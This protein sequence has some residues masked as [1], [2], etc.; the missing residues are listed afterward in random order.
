MKVSAGEHFA[1]FGKDEWI[2]CSAAAFDL[3]YLSRVTQS[4][5]DGPVYLRHA[6]QTVSILHAR[7][8]Y[9]MRLT[10]VAVAK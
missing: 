3:N 10:N 4:G 2:I 9:E 8:A 5:A 1:R 7:I 6:T